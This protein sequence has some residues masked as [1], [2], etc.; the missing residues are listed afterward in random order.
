MANA[1]LDI[2]RRYASGALSALSDCNTF[3][4]QR[5]HLSRISVHSSNKVKKLL[6]THPR[7]SLQTIGNV[8]LE[9]MK[10]FREF[11]KNN[12][13]FASEQCDKVIL[14][15]R[16]NFEQSVIELL[17]SYRG[18]IDASFDEEN[19]GK[20]FNLLAAACY[21]GS[22][23]ISSYLRI[24][25]DADPDHIIENVGP[26]YYYC[27][28]D[29]QVRCLGEYKKV[30][31]GYTPSLMLLFKHTENREYLVQK[32]EQLDTDEKIT[33]FCTN[34][35]N[36]SGENITFYALKWSSDENFAYIKS[37]TD[38]SRVNKYGE[39]AISLAALYH[40]ILFVNKLLEAGVIPTTNDLKMLSVTL[41]DFVIPLQ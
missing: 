15:R 1:S 22:S 35:L 37:L 19:T 41:P 38:I 9:N 4:L 26:I 16:V 31:P 14:E 28:H 39:S 20:K 33:D 5:W 24:V 10:S 34:L 7:L 30:I 11:M 13:F 32:L 3:E 27:E 8:I 18:N 36:D 23:N 21:I 40:E 25:R 12:F 17:E 2:S 6:K 29:Y